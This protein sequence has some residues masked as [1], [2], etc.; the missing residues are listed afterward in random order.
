MLRDLLPHDAFGR[1]DLREAVV[2]IDDEAVALPQP[3]CCVRSALRAHRSA[4]CAVRL[5]HRRLFIEASESS[6]YEDLL[7]SL[8]GGGI[9]EQIYVRVRTRRRIRIEQMPK[10]WALQQHA[11]HASS[12][13]RLPDLRALDVQA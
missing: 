10:C 11:T 1:A 7:G 2:K 3:C 12:V 13:E 8:D 5:P 9:D 4:H 6:R